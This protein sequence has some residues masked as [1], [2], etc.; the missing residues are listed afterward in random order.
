MI[1]VT[2]LGAVTALG[3]TANATWERLLAGDRGFRPVTLF[4]AEGYRSQIVAEVEG[5]PRGPQAGD[6]ARSRTSELGI[7]A[8]REALAQAGVSPASAAGGARV[9]LVMG[10]S[11]AGMLETES[12]LAVLVSPEGTVDPAVRQEALRRMLTHPLSAPTD[13]L[14][15]ELGPFSRV[16][17]VSSACSSGA[18]AVALA[19]TWLELGLCDVVLAGAADALC[20]VTMSGFHALAALEVDGAR[21][22]DRRRRGLTLGEGAGFLVMERASHAAAR[23]QRAI[24][25]LLGWAARSEA[26]HITNPEATGEAPWQAMRAALEMAKIGADDVDYVN[27]HG[28]ATPLNDPM[29]SNAL[30]RLF[31]D[32]VGEVGISSNKGQIGH[33]LAAA[34]AIEAVVTALAI[35]R[36]VVPPTGGFEEPDPA[37]I[38]PVRTAEVRPVRHALSNSFG[39]GGMDTVL[40]FGPAE[41]RRPDAPRGARRVVVTGVAALTPSSLLVGT[42]VADVPS[43]PAAGASVAPSALEVLDASRARRLDRASRLAT[44]A[45]AGALGTNAAPGTGVILGSAFGPVDASAVFMRRLREKGPRFVSP[46]DFPSLV[47]SSPAGYV[48][49]YLDLHGPSMI[50]AD[51]GTSGEA[52]LAQG[53]EMVAAGEAERIVV[54]AVE[55]RS[56]IVEQVLSVVFGARAGDAERAADAADIRKEGAGALALASLEEATSAGLPILAEVLQVVPWT[57]GDLP[58]RRAL[59]ATLVEPGDDAVAVVAS[60]DSKTE[61]LLAETSWNLVRRASCEEHAGTHEAVGGMAL[62]VAAAILA[63]GDATR[64]LCLG[65]ARGAGYAI[66]LSRCGA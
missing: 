60:L 31:G 18:N 3:A 25:T 32:R 61:E 43:L 57:A 33:T 22:F 9:G 16:R 64:A 14:A 12:L 58:R 38:L 52:A 17:S 28:T 45:A 50:V 20:R 30:R 11:T 27:A 46:A 24:C 13:R 41:P 15:Q 42:A 21:P 2:G 49:I 8:A 51:L 7:H 37:C 34:G 44:V 4:T 40:A 62:A 39:F 36:G 23:G 19:A 63:R 26:H 56:A 48:S 55:E 54:T 65:T 53:F 6:A 66:V 10:G 1:V 47:P 59:L 5:F 29:E 35:E